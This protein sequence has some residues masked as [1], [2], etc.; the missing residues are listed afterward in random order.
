MSFN[1]VASRACRAA[2]SV[3]CLLVVAGCNAQKPQQ[4]AAQSKGQVIAKVG[5]EDVTIH[6]LQNEYRLAGIAPDKVT[7]QIT[8]A[9]LEEITRRKSLAQKAIAGGLDREPTVLLDIL[10]GREQ[11]LA[12]AVLQRDIQVR[13]AG[14]GRTEIDRYINANPERFARRARFDVE[15]ITMNAIAARPEFMEAVKDA[16]SLDTVEKKLVQD[17]IPFSRGSGSIFSG[18]LPPELLTRLRNRKDTDIF[19]VRAGNGGTFFRIKAE[20]PDPLTGDMAQARGQALLRNETAQAEVVKKGEE[21]QVTYF[22]EYEKLME[23]PKTPAAS[24]GAPQS[25]AAPSR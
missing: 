3:A 5:N 20:V 18:D 12:T 13:V 9:L 8:R 4:Q 10:R 15:Q 2:I 14:I 11:I 17:N 25:P 16:T 21:A 6:E 1:A 23:K 24:E 7:E 19:F 22:G